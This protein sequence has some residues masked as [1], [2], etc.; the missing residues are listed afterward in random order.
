M[1][2]N[3]KKHFLGVVVNLLERHK[4]PKNKICG[5]VIQYI[6]NVAQ[7]APMPSIQNPNHPNSKG[8]HLLRRQPKARARP[9]L[10][11]GGPNNGESGDCDRNHLPD[12]RKIIELRRLGQETL[13]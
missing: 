4:I 10:P 3:D 7:L 2:R 11:E 9:P 13:K 12:S 1:L 8:L 6:E 5:F